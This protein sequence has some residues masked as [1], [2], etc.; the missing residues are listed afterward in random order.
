M[1]SKVVLASAHRQELIEVIQRKLQDMLGFKPTW[2]EIMQLLE[3]RE[4]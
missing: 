3:V 1:Y 2:E 4:K